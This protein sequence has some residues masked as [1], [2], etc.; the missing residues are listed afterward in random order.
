MPDLPLETWQSVLRNLTHDQQRPLLGVNRF[1]YSLA[2]RSLFS[3]VYL[4]IGAWET[5]HPAFNDQGSV[6]DLDARALRRSLDILNCIA[7]DSS[8]A[9]I[10]HAIVVQAY[11]KEC[12]VDDATW[13]ERQ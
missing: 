7:N 9:A 3:V 8:F 13:R 10:V 12:D 2:R 6:P 11:V 4:Y 1:L 5:T